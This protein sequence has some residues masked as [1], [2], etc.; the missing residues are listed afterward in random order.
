MCVIT[1][2]R[3]YGSGGDEIALRLSERLG[4]TLFD[5]RIIDQ[6]AAEVGLAETEVTDF[7]E[8]NHRVASFFERLFERTPV[9]GQSGFWGEEYSGAYLPDKVGL[10][11]DAMLSL[12]QKAVLNAHRMGGMII[13][14]R[15]GQVILK[16]LPG[17]LHLRIDAPVEDRI[18]R[19]K[20]QLKQMAQ[21]FSAT[22]DARRE[23]QDRILERDAA[24]AD[25]LKRFYNVAWN[26][27]LLY[28]MILNT[29]RMT[30]PQAVNTVVEF[31]HEMNNQM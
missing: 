17:V 10:N 27:P 3:T 18:Q 24:S 1:L 28:H 23:A 4:Y 5:K 20:E 26:D 16:D 22:I 15:G 30:I 9:F 2:S 12:V 13:V 25:Y 6:T 11:E 29:G 7:S 31:C 8:E 19:V 21:A 14:G